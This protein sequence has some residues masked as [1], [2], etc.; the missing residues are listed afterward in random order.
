VLCKL[1]KVDE[2]TSYDGLLESLTGP[3]E[4]EWKKFYE[5]DEPTE[6]DLP[7]N[8]DAKLKPVQRLLVARSVRENLWA[9][10]VKRFIR[11]ELGALFIESPPFDLIGSFNESSNV[12]PIIFILSPGADPT[13]YLIKLAADMEYSERLHFISLGQG[14]GPKAEKL[15]DQ[16]RET[17][18]WCALQNCHLAASWM[19]ALERIQEV[20]AQEGDSIDA[21]Y[22]L[23]L[24]SM[25]T[26]IFPVPVLQSGI[27]ITNEPPKGLKS[28]L[29]RSFGDITEEIYEASAGT[30][31]DAP[32]KKLLFALA[33]FHAVILQRRKFG[34]I[35][36]NIAYE[37]MD[38]DFQTSREQ[39]YMYLKTQ[40]GV[41]LRTLNYMVAECNYGG[42]VTDDKD[43][44]LIC[45]ILERYF[46][47]E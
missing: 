28:N 4:E 17:G 31:K 42:R 19:P 22:R 40:E 12:M 33:F 18:D 2:I 23:W 15:M 14:Q 16:C 8:F 43:V 11:E 9:L 3:H 46:S 21:N 34:P 41:P 27:K 25:P 44:R 30:E 7:D 6:W 32:Y 29:A 36:W 47:H 20:A 35:G 13:Q 10:G 24:T 26:P 38:S 37:W 45:C 39:L 5:A 1:A